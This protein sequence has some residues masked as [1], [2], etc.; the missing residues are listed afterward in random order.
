MPIGFYLWS[1]TMQIMWLRAHQKRA[2]PKKKEG[3]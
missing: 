2:N 1:K 3:K